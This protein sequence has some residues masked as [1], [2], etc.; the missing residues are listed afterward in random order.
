MRL[1]KLCLDKV[2][3]AK[4]SEYSLSGGFGQRPTMAEFRSCRTNR[5]QNF[6]P[7]VTRP[8]QYSTRRQHAS[9]TG[10]RDR[11]YWHIT[12]DR[13]NKCTGPKSA[14]PRLLDKRPFWKECQ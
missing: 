8:R 10:Q 5:R 7:D 14:N 9:R 4:H 1:N 6:N 3:L 11:Y 2:R 12:F 13:G